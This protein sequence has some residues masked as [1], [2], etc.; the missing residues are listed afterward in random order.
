MPVFLLYCCFN[1]CYKGRNIGVLTPWCAK[2][3]CVL[4]HARSFEKNV[5][6]AMHMQL[7]V[8]PKTKI[9]LS[10]PRYSTHRG[11]DLKLCYIAPNRDSALCYLAP[12]SAS[13]LCNI[14]P[15]GDSALC[16]V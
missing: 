7:S 14:A 3:L 2:N 9:F 5:L 10:P 11:I 6:S 15:S 8:K 16:N 1:G 4:L 13:A 12:S